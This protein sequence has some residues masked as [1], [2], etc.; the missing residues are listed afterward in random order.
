VLHR[1]AGAISASETA[2]PPDAYDM[3]TTYLRLPDNSFLRHPYAC[4]QYD[5]KMEAIP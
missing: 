5:K 1:I 4:L 2:E 3:L